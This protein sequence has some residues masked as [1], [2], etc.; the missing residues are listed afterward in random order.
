[1]RR[2]L[3]RAPRIGTHAAHTR[4]PTSHTPPDLSRR[5]HVSP[6]ARLSLSYVLGFDHFCEFVGNDIG[7]GNLSCF[8]PFLVLLATLSTY[9]VFF[10][11]WVVCSY[12][13]PPNAQWHLL[14]VPWRLAIAAV[15]T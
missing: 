2:A 15:L 13:T 8:V 12:F 14:L 11:T 1:M 6:R 4:R 7:K 10:S 3:A 5:V 9:V